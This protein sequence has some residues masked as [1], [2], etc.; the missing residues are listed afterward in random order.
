MR[1]GSTPHPLPPPKP[2]AL[3]TQR[4]HS[5]CPLF[6]E[7]VSEQ[8]GRGAPRGSVAALDPESS[9]SGYQFN[10]APPWVFH[11]EK[12]Y[13]LTGTSDFQQV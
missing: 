2:N 11:L 12:M 13:S 5:Q 8:W 9:G 7:H 3:A 10:T 4:G 1:W 6:R